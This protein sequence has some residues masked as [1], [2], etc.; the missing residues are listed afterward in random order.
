MQFLS[1]ESLFQKFK[2]EI[3]DSP[4]ICLFKADYSEKQTVNNL[5]PGS[6]IYYQ[7][8]E[9]KHTGSMGY[10]AKRNGV[11][12]IVTA[13]HEVKSCSILVYLKKY[14][15]VFC[16]YAFLLYFLLCS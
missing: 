8:S 16:I 12:G 5:N 13:G 11:T 14:D 1:D 3:S 7:D 4:A 15:F 2:S 10:R 6:G 9:G